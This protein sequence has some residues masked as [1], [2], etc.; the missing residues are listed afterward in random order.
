NSEDGKH[1]LF[2]EDAQYEYGNRAE[3]AEHYADHKGDAVGWLISFFPLFY[4]ARH[5]VGKFD[6]FF[7]QIFKTF[8]FSCIPDK[9]RYCSSDHHQQYGKADCHSRSL[10]ENIS[11]LFIGKPAEEDHEDR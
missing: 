1:S 10:R 6:R 5:T 11:A 4:H 7:F 9:N 2:I 3:D 8:N